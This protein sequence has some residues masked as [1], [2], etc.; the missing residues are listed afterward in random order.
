MDAYQPPLDTRML[1]RVAGSLGSNPAGLFED[2][3]GGRFYVKTLESPAHARNEFIAAM[4][5]RLAGVPTLTYLRTLAP[6]QVATEW[7]TL[8]KTHLS[9]FSESECRQA[10]H[11]FGV[12]AWTANWDVAGFDGDNLGIVNGTVLTLD[13]GGALEFRAQGDPK[14]NAFGIHVGELDTLR[15]DADNRHAVRL[16]GDMCDDDLR[17]AIEVVTRIPDERIRQVIIEHGGSYT[18]ADKMVARKADMARRLA[19]P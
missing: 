15:H 2:E 6:D 19:A 10:Q 17:L 14:G 4:V 13:V 16:F 7:I 8:E 3:G 1:R 5:Y 11:W 9:Q 12:Y 18:L